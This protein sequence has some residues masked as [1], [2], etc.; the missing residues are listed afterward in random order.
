MLE[1]RHGSVRRPVV[2]P[3]IH[4]VFH[5]LQEVANKFGVDLF[6]LA[7]GKLAKLCKNVIQ[8]DITPPCNTHVTC[9]KVVVYNSLFSCVGQTRRCLNV[10]LQEHRTSLGAAP[11]GH[12]AIYVSDCGCRP[13][14]SHISVLLSSQHQKARE[15]KEGNVMKGRGRRLFEGEIRHLCGTFGI[16][17]IGLNAMLRYWTVQIN[18]A[19]KRDN[20]N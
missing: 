1:E 8:V 2:I 6:F 11:S 4:K 20:K 14:F 18:G 15:L 7:P 10:H 9:A 16:V 5:G 19:N 13:L 17:G 3:Y 12:L